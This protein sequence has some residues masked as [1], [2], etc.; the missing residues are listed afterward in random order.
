MFIAPKWLPIANMTMPNHIFLIAYWM[1]CTRTTDI[2]PHPRYSPD[3]TP[4]DFW[5]SPQLMRQTFCKQQRMCKGCVGSF[6]KALTKRTYT[7]F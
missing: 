6:D 2:L 1:F 3:K 7:C 4:Y 5:L